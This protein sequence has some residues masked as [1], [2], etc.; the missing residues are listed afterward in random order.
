MEKRATLTGNPGTS[1]FRPIQ[2]RALDGRFRVSSLHTL[3]GETNPIGGPAK[4]AFR[5]NR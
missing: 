1:S 2:L 3:N 4:V 5:R